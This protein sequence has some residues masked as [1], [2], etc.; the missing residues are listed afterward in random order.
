MEELIEK[1]ANKR[2]FRNE[3]ASTNNSP[4]K[5]ISKTDDLPVKNNQT[6]LPSS[7]LH[8]VKKNQK[9]ET[10]SELL[11]KSLAKTAD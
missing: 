8:S 5:K 6:T 9:S 10:T 2:Q 11:H 4:Y 1:E 7:L 3:K